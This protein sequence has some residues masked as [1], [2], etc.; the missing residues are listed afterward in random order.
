MNRFFTLLIL[1]AAVM[2]FSGCDHTIRGNDGLIRKAREVIPVSD[3]DELE[4][5]LAGMCRKDGSVL[6]WVI[7]GNE[8]QRHYYLPME[9][10]V[11]QSQA[12]DNDE[13]YSYIHSFK[14]Y[15][16]CIDIASMQWMGGYSFLVNNKLCRSV[17]ITDENGTHEY[18]VTEIP[19]VIYY[20]DSLNF[21]YNYIDIDG[22]E[23]I[24]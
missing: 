23:M 12:G 10:T 20:D 1:L 22:N 14:P 18:P 15:E 5:N 2:M 7:S 21:E 11:E 17:R 9:F 3:A 24:P 8:N 6:V 13:Q 16:R 19:C 4:M